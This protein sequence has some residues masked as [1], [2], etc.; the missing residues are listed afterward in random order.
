MATNGMRWKSYISVT[1][2]ILALR[3]LD[4]VLTYRY[5]PDL[6]HEWNPLVSLFGV[7]W[8]GFILTQLLIVVFVSAMMFFYFSRESTASFQNG[9]S[10]YDFSY[11][12]FFGKLRPWP[13]RIFSFPINLKRHL[14][15]NGFL[16]M[17]ITILISGFAIV[18]NLL[19]IHGAD[20][21]IRFVS[22]HYGVYF[23]LCFIT[24]AVFTLFLFFG[25]EYLNYRR[26]QKNA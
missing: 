4:L 16:F 1:G 10:F 13:D 21:Y 23:P 18:H 15:F 25:I 5:T 20:S 24:V 19:L 12:Y 3:S 14:V 26:A 11:V 7:S 17:L 22:K 9:L 8:P 2:V 6:R